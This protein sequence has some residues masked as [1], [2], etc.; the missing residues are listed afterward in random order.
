MLERR[1]AAVGEPLGPAEDE[2]R[3]PL[4]RRPCGERLAGRGEDA[5]AGG[6]PGDEQELAR[7][8]RVGRGRRG[9][10]SEAAERRSGR[11]RRR[12]AIPRGGRHAGRAREGDGRARERERERAGQA[13]AS[14]GER[15]RE[16]ALREATPERARPGVD[17]RPPGALIASDSIGSPS[18]SAPTTTDE[19]TPG[20]D[21]ERNVMR[22]FRAG[23]LTDGRTD[24]TGPSTLERLTSPFARGP[25]PSEEEAG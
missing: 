2:D 19:A 21:T 14:A 6:G 25:P 15:E 1:L 12:G 7:V 20:S 4:D 24:Q 17:V 18:S 11:R 22:A 8:E 16:R 23:R 5:P 10:W 3:R 13:T 9:R